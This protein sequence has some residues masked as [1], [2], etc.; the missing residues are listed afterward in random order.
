MDCDFCPKYEPFV[1]F[2]FQNLESIEEQAAKYQANEKD[3]ESNT[4][5][6]KQL[7]KF[8]TVLEWILSV[9]WDNESSVPP[10]FFQFIPLLC[11]FESYDPDPE[12]AQ[13]SGVALS[14]LARTLINPKYLEL[15]LETLDKVKTHIKIET[16][17]HS[18]LMSNT[19]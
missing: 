10:C 8:K 11:T 7:L 15:V 9:C 4:E 13:L 18:H 3:S 6:R 1:E 5:I 14:G 12:I 16:I 19:K 17:S 2:L